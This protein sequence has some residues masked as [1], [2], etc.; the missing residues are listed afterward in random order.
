MTVAAANAELVRA[1]GTCFD[2]L[3]VAAWLRY[4]DGGL[5]QPLRSRAPEIRA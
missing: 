2:P 1:A 4:A 5:I 3:L